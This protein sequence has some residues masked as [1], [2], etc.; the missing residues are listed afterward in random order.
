[1]FVKLFQM[2][3]KSCENEDRWAKKL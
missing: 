3:K 2:F 1:M